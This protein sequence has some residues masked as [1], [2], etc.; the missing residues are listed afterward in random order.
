MVSRVAALGVGQL[1]ALISRE[2]PLKKALGPRL[3]LGKAIPP[4][5]GA[6]GVCETC[7]CFIA[8]SKF[9]HSYFVTKQRGMAKL[10][11]SNSFGTGLFED[12]WDRSG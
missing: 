7:V 12:K 8:T 4:V 10:Y 1:I 2:T 11:Q 5:L 6:L 9:G 3:L